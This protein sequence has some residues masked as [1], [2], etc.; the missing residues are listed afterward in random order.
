MP[1]LESLERLERSEFGHTAEIQSAVYEE[2]TGE[3]RIARQTRFAINGEPYEN[4]ESEETPLLI[5]SRKRRL[6]LVFP[7]ANSLIAPTPPGN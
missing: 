7:V 2:F 3:P 1:K 6:S 5:L 4:K